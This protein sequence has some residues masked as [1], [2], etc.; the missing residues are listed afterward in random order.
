[1]LMS[2]V[3]LLASAD[4]LALPWHAWTGARPLTRALSLAGLTPMYVR[5]PGLRGQRD[6][7]RHANAFSRNAERAVHP[8]P[9]HR[10]PPPPPA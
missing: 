7:R 4:L 6:S 2:R 8:C 10:A 3:L 9:I 1:M 5:P